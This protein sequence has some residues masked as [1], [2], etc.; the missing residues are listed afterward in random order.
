[1]S[2]AIAE[3]RRVLAWLDKEG[4]PVGSWQ[5]ATVTNL[6]SH[7]ERPV[8]AEVEKEAA[9]LET[10]RHP[11]NY[12][13]AAMLR[14][15]AAE[16][17]SY[18]QSYK[19]SAEIRGHLQA[20]LSRLTAPVTGDRAELVKRLRE[21]KQ[22]GVFA[23]GLKAADMLEADARREVALAEALAALRADG[24]S[25]AV[26]NDYRLNGEPHTFWLF[27]HPNGTWLKGEGRTD[28]EAVTAILAKLSAERVGGIESAAERIYRVM[29]DGNLPWHLATGDD[30]DTCREYARAALAGRPDGGER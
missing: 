4:Y 21:Q 10:E 26:H 9:W 23:L 8:D 27:T 28:E 14:S 11:R 22:D 7:V 24:W 25:V 6:L 2:D 15:L 3:A 19:E 29:Y 16:R 5:H 20:E 13:I 17:D 30:Q 18:A 1:M 12:H